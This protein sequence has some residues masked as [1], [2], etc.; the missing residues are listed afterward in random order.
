ML[1]ST[2][3]DIE[4][5]ADQFAGL[6]KT[7]E[8]WLRPPDV[9]RWGV[10]GVDGVEVVGRARRGTVGRRRG[11]DG[12]E[13]VSS[14]LVADS[15]R[16]ILSKRQLRR[17]I[18]RTPTV[19]RGLVVRSNPKWRQCGGARSMVARPPLYSDPRLPDGG[20]VLRPWFVARPVA[21]RRVR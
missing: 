8:R 17:A 13:D 14:T 21:R 16:C 5:L 19:H 9:P 2:A 3:T 10:T 18:P 15:D 1:A 6:G 4:H 20:Q 7:L 11:R 12:H